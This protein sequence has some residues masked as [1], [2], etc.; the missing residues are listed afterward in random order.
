MLHVVIV[1]LVPEKQLSAQLQRF[2][3]NLVPKYQQLKTPFVKIEEQLQLRRS[4]IVRGRVVD[5]QL[6]RGWPLALPCHAGA[7]CKFKWAYCF[8]LSLD[9]VSEVTS[10]LRN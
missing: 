10:R 3:I 7:D 4:C 8:L 2:V 9:L 6:E 5:Q 1:V